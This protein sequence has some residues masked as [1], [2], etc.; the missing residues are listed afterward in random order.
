MLAGFLAFGEA[1][2]YED[3]SPKW[4]FKLS[5]TEVEPF[6]TKYQSKRVF[7]ISPA[8]AKASKNWTAEGYAAVAQ[9]A[10]DEG[11]TVVLTGGNGKTDL[12]LCGRIESTLAGKC[13]NLCGKTTLRQLCALTSI[14]A[15]A[16]SPDSALM[17]LASALHVPVIGLFAIHNPKR[18][19]SWNFPDLWVSV[20]QELAKEELG[21]RHI[22][23]RY[24]VKT[25]KA[26][27]RISI[28]S[29][30]DMFD[31]ALEQYNL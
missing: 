10:L 24:R 18:V 1:I 17:H 31:R 11:F 19:G 12:D 22:P 8:S 26:M 3:L 27:E 5:R 30:T 15:M 2:G 29:V 6:Q 21:N 20:W 7:L 13:D 23:W 28:E 9:H 14:S 16:L 4:D 25:E